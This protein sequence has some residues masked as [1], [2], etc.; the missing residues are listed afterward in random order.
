MCHVCMSLLGALREERHGTQG[1]Q[2][3]GRAGR[4]A[5]VPVRPT[6]ER[7]LRKQRPSCSLARRGGALAQRPHGRCVQYHPQ[8]PPLGRRVPPSALSV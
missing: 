7:V 2:E 4:T 8:V 1:E 3:D 6:W 5:H